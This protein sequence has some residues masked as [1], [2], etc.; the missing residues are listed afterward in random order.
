MK[1]KQNAMNNNSFHND[2]FTMYFKSKKALLEQLRAQ[3]CHTDCSIILNE[4]TNDIA[5]QKIEL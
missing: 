5:Q 1:I 4:I 3:L 2:L